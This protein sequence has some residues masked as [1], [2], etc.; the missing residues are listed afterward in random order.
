VQLGAFYRYTGQL[1]L[2]APM[3]EAACSGAVSAL[4]SSSP[5][6]LY[7]MEELGALQISQGKFA[8]AEDLFRIILGHLEGKLG[9]EH[10]DV[11][12]VRETL[13]GIYLET[14]DFEQALEIQESTLAMR[15]QGHGPGHLQVASAFYSLGR[16]YEKMGQ[17]SKA[18]EALAQAHSVSLQ[19]LGPAHPWTQGIEQDIFRLQQRPP[20]AGK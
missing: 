18:L 15:Q 12:K 19:A 2:A 10:V 17:P 9:H 13:A 1:E 8:A 6:A 5:V 3:L 7:A 4:G 16:I 14:E 20:V 11:M